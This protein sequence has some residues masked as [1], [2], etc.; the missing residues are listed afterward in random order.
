[1]VTEGKRIRGLRDFFARSF[2]ESELA[3]FLTVN[4][5]DEVASA[6][7]QQAGGIEY[8]F[9]VAQALQ[10]RGLIDGAFF[11]QLRRE[12]PKQGARISVLQQSWLARDRAV[13]EPSGGMPSSVLRNMAESVPMAPQHPTSVLRDCPYPGMRAFTLDDGFPF[14]G[15]DRESEELLQNLR[16]SRFLAV[17]G[18]SGSGKSSLVYAGLVPR[19][20]KTSL[21][22]PIEWLVRSMRPGEQPL[23]E[24]TRTLGIDSA[25]PAAAVAHA[26]E[27]D[28]EAKRLL[29]VVDQ[30]EAVFALGQGKSQPFC[31][32]LQ[33]LLN[34]ERVAVVLTVRADF[35]AELMG[36]P[37]WPQI[38]ANRVDIGPLD[39][40]G[41]REAISRPAE[42]VGVSVESA[43]VERLV[44]DAVEARS[45]GI[46]PLVQEVLVQLWEKREGQVLPL[47]AYESFISARTAYNRH[48]DDPQRTGLEVA[49]ARHADGVLKRLEV[50]DPGQ[51]EIARRIFLRLVQFGEGRPDTRRQQ[52]VA[53]LRA[54][55]DPVRFETILSCLARNRLVT[56]TADLET[57]R[58]RA[59]I[60]HEAL[61]HGWPQLQ[62]WIEEWRKAEE[63]RRKLEQKAQEWI[64]AGTDTEG[65][66]GTGGLA[67]AE[68]WVTSP[69]GRELPEDDPIRRLIRESRAHI[70]RAEIERETTRQRE[71]EAARRLAAEAEARRL[72]EVERAREA[73]RRAREQAEAARRQSRL[74]GTLK[75]VAAVAV[76]LAAAAFSS[77][78][79]AMK[80]TD[81]ANQQKTS[82]EEN[83]QIAQE[84]TKTAHHEA[85]RARTLLLLARSQKILDQKPQLALLLTLEALR[86]LRD[87]GEYDL[88]LAN[89]SGREVLNLTFSN[90]SGVGLY[91]HA[92]RVNHLAYAPDGRT[93][94]TASSDGTVRLWD[95]AA[96]PVTP[97]R[98]LPHDGP[99]RRLVF[100][101]DGRTLAVVAASHKGEVW[102]WDLAA[103][104][105]AAR[106]RVLRRAERVEQLAIAPEGR[107]LATGHGDG[108]VRLWDLTAPDPAARPRVLKGAE[109]SII[110]VAFAP[111]GRVLAALSAAGE[112]R[113]WDLTTSDPAAEPRVLRHDGQITYVAFAPDGRT[114]ASATNGGVVRLWDLASS[115][116]AAGP[117][118]L[119]HSWPVLKVA[120]APDGRTLVAASGNAL[121]LWDLATAKLDRHPHPRHH[122]RGHDHTILQVEFGPDGKTVASLSSDGTA[123]L[124]D[125][126]APGQMTNPRVFR[127]EDNV[128]VYRVAFTPDGKTL[129][130]A[131]ADG[132]VRL[133]DLTAPDPAAHPHILPHGQLI[134]L[135]AIA[136]DGRTLASALFNSGDGTV[137]L[138]DL[139]APDPAARP[140]ILHHD[141]PVLHID[142]TPDNRTLATGTIDGTVR[143]WDLTAPDPA[144]Q[145]GTI[146]HPGLAW[147]AIAPDGRML[148]SG[149]REGVDTV[150]LW[151]LTAPDPVRAAR[152]LRDDAPTHYLAFAPGGKT[153]AAAGGDG[154]VRLWDLTASDPATGPHILNGH[155]GE[156]S[157]VAFA[158][159][160]KTLASGAVKSGDGTFRLWDLT[161]PDP[162]VSPRVIKGHEKTLHKLVFAPDG[163]RL[164]TAS[165]DG[166]V[167]VWDLMAADPAAGARL[168]SRDASVY[169]LAFS[170]DG[171]T[172]VTARGDGT[173][174]LWMLD[175]DQLMLQARSKLGRN[176]TPDEWTQ[177]LSATEPYHR[178]FPDLPVVAEGAAPAER[179]P[180][181]QALHLTETARAGW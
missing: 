101:P 29:L 119:H 102:L 135:L 105:P 121:L 48:P 104:D 14:F 97:P 32:A 178:T 111:Q 82:A 59:D 180:G 20:R 133:W 56:L 162:A 54:S 137:R 174:R 129:A 13:P 68:M 125:L 90:L 65:L 147:F 103:S 89:Q 5:Y 81:E 113:L 83:E 91:G 31:Q 85:N 145:P 36:T 42:M 39:E 136:P 151:D 110:Q 126:A 57:C 179:E 6:V 12:R 95:V 122:L 140:R 8:S 155:R 3:M 30:F 143:L 106:P 161:A 123:R 181:H 24:L 96:V 84:E 27:A 26:L 107:R 87:L 43:L 73:E 127:H 25:D 1:M 34:V 94:A 55:N 9:A 16:Q 100:A 130:S 2:T 28:R 80:A 17:I 169:D 37:L 49:I 170:P 92:G 165:I 160:G 134:D 112:A 62:R 120:I 159:D 52:A 44:S 116:P 41:L 64:D 175:R 164:A 33:S 77:L 132:T 158:P 146:Q 53:Q 19:L 109:G 21:L 124:W 131:S 99:A 50:E 79:L 156:I 11:E 61:I 118:L 154:T 148:A 67:V 114:L 128:D 10:R 98:V 76:A 88:D 58:R 63:I 22:G 117:M 163:E 47:H 18:G 69:D 66:L 171:Q 138:W 115:D 38:K 149:S 70:H 74:A 177:Y 141:K 167:R 142:F 7:N 15:R 71:L 139:T 46:L 75:V 86:L 176:L 51:V 153:L 172:L 157:W 35:Y 144:A 40:A 60:A 166:T 173:V 150:R 45:L 93:L 108:T 168:F 78:Y 4:G 23:A 152:V 72:A